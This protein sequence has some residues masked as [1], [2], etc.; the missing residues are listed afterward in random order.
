MPDWLHTA[1]AFIAV[2]ALWGCT[3]PLLNRGSKGM[4]QRA[5]LKALPVVQ[6][7]VAEIAYIV[8]QWRFVVP[9]IINQ[10]GSVVYFGVISSEGTALSLAYPICNALATLFTAVTSSLL[11]EEPLTHRMSL[12]YFSQSRYWDR[13]HMYLYW[14]STVLCRSSTPVKCQR[15]SV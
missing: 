4:E 14:C 7:A 12:P 15:I 1:L 9:F 11:G 5:D 3:N 8:S 10:L 6:R 2:G 13:N